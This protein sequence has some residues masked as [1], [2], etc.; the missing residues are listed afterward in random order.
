MTSLTRRDS[1]TARA[2]A[3]LRGLDGRAAAGA[4]AARGMAL[5]VVS[6]GSTP[7]RY[8][9]ALSPSGRL[10]AR[11]RDARRRTA[12]ARR[13]PALQRAA[14]AR[15]AAAEPRRE[16]Q[17]VRSPI[18]GSRRSRSSPPRGARRRAAAARRSRRARH[19]RRRPHRFVVSAAPTVWPRRS[20]R[21]RARWSRRS[22]A[23]RAGAAADADRPRAAARARARAADR[24]AGK[25][26]TFARALED[27][28]VEDMPIRAVLRGAAD[29]LT[30]FEAGQA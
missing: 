27:G 3:G 30:I 5:L 16:A 7:K 26:A 17:F 1:P 23:R 12:R 19:G 15:D 29:R 18:R 28:P 8:F 21:R 13:Q 9:A 24:R 14:G 10:V 20:I 11:R 4:I 2:R 22:R 6:G 25:A